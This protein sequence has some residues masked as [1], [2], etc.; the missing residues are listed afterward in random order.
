MKY[1]LLLTCLYLFSNTT[2]GM[3]KPRR[4]GSLGALSSAR[5]RSFSFGGELSRSRK[6]KNS[7]IKKIKSSE[8]SLVKKIRDMIKK[9]RLTDKDV[10]AI[11]FYLD[12]Y[13]K[14]KQKI[15]E[16]GLELD[17]EPPLLDFKNVEKKD[18]KGCTALYKVVE[19]SNEFEKE[20][21]ILSSVLESKIS[22]LLVAGAKPD[23]KCMNEKSS[24]DIAL[25]KC[26]K[27]LKAWIQ[28]GVSP[29]K[30]EIINTS[31]DYWNIKS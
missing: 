12:T 1:Q 6:S 10:D 19:L 26:K 2:L 8:S 13:K 31:M 11:E 3:N 9:N 25:P 15:K 23:T 14:N 22:L 30:K 18:D 16:I 7:D 27:L 4:G 28:D 24:I 29:R 21:G 17:K 20:H 5:P